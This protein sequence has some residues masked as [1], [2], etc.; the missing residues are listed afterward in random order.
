M[1][2]FA[3]AVLILDWGIRLLALLTIPA[4]HPPAAAR[5]WLLLVGF[6]PLFG[7]PIYL[8]LSRPWL[9]PVRISR[10]REVSAQIRAAHPPLVGAVDAATVDACAGLIRLARRLGDLPA[11]AG[12]RVDLLADYAGAIDDLAAGIDAAQTRVDLLYYIVADDASGVRVLAAL[13]R[14]RARGVACR[15]LVDALASKTF[16]HTSADALRADGIDVRA[17]LLDRLWAAAGRLDLRNHRKLAIVDA[18]VGWLGSQNLVSPD[19]IIGAPNVELVARVRGPVVAQLQAIF[20]GDWYIETGQRIDSGVPIVPHAGIALTQMIPGGP[21]YP[22]ENARDIVVALIQHARREIMLC[23]PYFVP[24]E[25]VL[26]ALCIAALS[27]VEVNLIVSARSN[28]A[29]VDWAQRAYYAELLRSG[30][31]IHR[32]QPG[33]LHAKHISV[34]AEIGMIGSINLDVRSFALNAESGLLVYSAEVTARLQTLQRGYIG[35]S[36]ELTLEE[37]QRRPLWQRSVEG[38]ARLA[39]GFL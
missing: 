30:V 27:G 4:R 25:A 14:A 15:L 9:A 1:P 22:F 26:R 16:L 2:S 19:F 36:I 8:L 28:Q 35:D 20:D 11:C 21:A 31:R 12:N 33:F 38:L 23:T 39:N 3:A 7:L 32:F 13:R 34:D 37:W 6:V 24:D 10:Q 5:T 18:T 29:L 17:M